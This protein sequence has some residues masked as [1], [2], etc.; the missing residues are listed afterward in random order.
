[1]NFAPIL[2]WCDANREFLVNRSVCLR[3]A[4]IGALAAAVLLTGCGRKG[5]LDP[6]P[7]ASAQPAE[8]EQLQVDAEG[9]PV[10]PRGQKK[11]FFADWLLD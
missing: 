4:A 3:L 10:A 7:S 9:R 5:P 2:L 6:P 8:P 1:V 11:R